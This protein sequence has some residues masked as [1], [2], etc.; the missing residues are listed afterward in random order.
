MG[1]KV[2][3]QGTTI[4]VHKCDSCEKDQNWNTGNNYNDKF[5]AGEYLC[6]DAESLF[7]P[8][9][10]NNQTVKVRRKI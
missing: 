5:A 9:E 10:N 1:P 8:K 3:V 4:I 6:P 2:H 7:L